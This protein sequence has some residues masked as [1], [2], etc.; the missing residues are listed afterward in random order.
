MPNHHLSPGTCFHFSK[1]T[2]KALLSQNYLK[3]SGRNHKCISTTTK[4]RHIDSWKVPNRDLALK[5][6][7][8]ILSHR[9]CLVTGGMS[10]L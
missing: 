10:N 9:S 3:P 6:S 8:G 1:T 4:L 2:F 7:S 5:Q